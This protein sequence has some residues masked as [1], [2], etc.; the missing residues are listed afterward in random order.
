MSDSIHSTISAGPVSCRWR[1]RALFT[2]KL[3]VAAGLLAWLFASGRLNFSALW[4]ARYPHLF[5]LA[6]L[7]LLVSLLALVWRWK[8]LLEVQQLSMPTLKALRFTWLGLFANLYLPGAAG[9]DLAKACAACRDQPT[10]KTRAVS[11]VFMDRLLGLHSLLFVGSVAGLTVLVGG[12]TARQAG[13]IWVLLLCF[14]AASTGLLLLLLRPSSD[15][16]LR[17]LPQRLRTALADSLDLYRRE[18][19]KLVWIWIYSG[20]CNLLAIASYVLV[21]AA[22]GIGAGFAQVLAVPLVIVT[23]SLPI[24]PGGFGVGE[25]AGSQLFVEF[26]LANGG[27]VVLV[28]RM[29]IAVFSIP[30]VA[31]IFLRSRH[32]GI[33]GTLETIE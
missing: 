8:W 7:V 30:G 11:T 14:A 6:G 20:F 16:V 32:V 19:M 22:L 3:S 10:A 2:V 25:A 5:L 28:V 1:R 21:G 13:V 31:C 9:G 12:C 4:A 33:S 23:M 15:L 18:R 26:G 29:A 24:S 17:M 27:L